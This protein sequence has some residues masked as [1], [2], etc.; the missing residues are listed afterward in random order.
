[1]TISRRCWCADISFT[2]SASFAGSSGRKQTV[3]PAASESRWTE[4]GNTNHPHRV[5]CAPHY[6]RMYGD[7]GV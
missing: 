7:L 1:M 5:T 2:G 3:Q 4:R 6:I